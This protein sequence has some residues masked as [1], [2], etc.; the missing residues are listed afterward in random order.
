MKKL[1]IIQML[2]VLL[3]ILCICGTV[4]AY[5]ADGGE[6]ESTTEVYEESTET[7]SE[8]ISETIS[9]T[10]SETVSEIISETVSET[11]DPTETTTGDSA[12]IDIP[13]DALSTEAT[14][15]TAVEELETT[16][17]QTTE[18]PT[19]ETTTEATTETTTETATET[20]TNKAE[21]VTQHHDHSSGG[22]GGGGSGGTGGGVFRS[23][24]S[25]LA[26]KQKT[27]TES[28]TE[29]TTQS[30]SNG[31]NKK[32]DEKFLN[33]LKQKKL[34]YFIDSPLAWLDK[35]LIN[36]VYS[37]YIQKH[38]SSALISVRSLQSGLGSDAEITW[39][40]KTKTAVVKYGAHTAKITANSS[41]LIADGKNVYFKNGAY[42]EI[43]DGRIYLPFRALGEA[44]GFK[45]SWDSEKRAAVYFI[46]E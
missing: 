32:P 14:S 9:E 46:P 7:T 41:Y 6:E 8:T 24:F 21:P 43:K 17:R 40:P 37:P 16:T 29:I 4:N 5:S 39:L 45:V 27:E 19:A 31:I 23:N 44:L 25:E 26:D 3:T 15:K 42:A 38:S 34:T 28:E 10:T 18:K 35:R 2:F 11:E 20:T 30:A 1:K 12:G 33:I 13:S 36:I 22:G